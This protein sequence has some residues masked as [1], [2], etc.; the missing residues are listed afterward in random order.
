MPGGMT[1]CADVG[2]KKCF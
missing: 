2:I 1:H